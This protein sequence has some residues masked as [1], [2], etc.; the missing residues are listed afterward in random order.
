MPEKGEEKLWKRGRSCL[1]FAK[2]SGS[3]FLPLAGACGGGDRENNFWRV[4]RV[5]GWSFEA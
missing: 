4:C 2:K 1:E 5:V 3:R